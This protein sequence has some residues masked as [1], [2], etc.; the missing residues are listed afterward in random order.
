MPN[1]IN[2]HAISYSEFVINARHLKNEKLIIKKNS[3][4]IQNSG[5]WGKLS[6]FVFKETYR[7]QKQETVGKYLSAVEQQIKNIHGREEVSIKIHALFNK[8]GTTSVN[9]DVVLDIHHV[10][11]A[12]MEKDRVL[13]N[14][15]KVATEFPSLFNKILCQMVPLTGEKLIRMDL[16]DKGGS[17]PALVTELNRASKIAHSQALLTDHDVV[18][19]LKETGAFEKMNAI[20]NAMIGGI[21]FSQWASRARTDILLKGKTPVEANVLAYALNRQVAQCRALN[22]QILDGMGA[23]DERRRNAFSASFQQSGAHIAAAKHLIAE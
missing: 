8:R 4:H 10:I 1:A 21:R 12:A 13:A 11:H 23:Q 16:M 6:R 2:S 17:L 22:A 18:T 15:K 3:V 9:A 7:K 5:V 14:A 19:V 20:G